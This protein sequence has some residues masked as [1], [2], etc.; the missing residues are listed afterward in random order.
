MI[1]RFLP[2]YRPYK[3][4]AAV[5]LGCA[6]GLGLADLVFPAATAR[7]VDVIV[8]AGDLSGLARFAALLVALYAVRAALE[9]IVGYYGHVLGVNIQHDLRRDIYRH[10]HTMDT[11]FFDNTK[12]G[13]IM[14]R[15]VGDLFDLAEISHHL[16]EDIIMAS[17]RLVGSL[18]VMLAIEWRLAL[19]V[20]AIVPVLVAFSATFREKFR[21]A[22]RRNKE[23]MAAI[24]ERIEES[25]SGVR[26]VRA[27]GNEGFEAERFDEGNATFRKSRIES[28]W[29]IGVFSTGVSF[30]SNLGLV[31]V[32]TAGGFAAFKGAVSL[33]SYVAFALYVSRFFQPIETLV[34][35]M[36]M[37]QEGAA[38]FRRFLEILDTEPTISDAPDA[39]ALA[40]VCG[41]VEFSGV[42]F[43]YG[44]GKERVLER[45][46]LSVAAGETVAIVGP[47]GAGKTTLCS[48]IPRFYDIEEG[49]ITVD[50]LDIRRATIAS[51]R[52][53]V[54]LVQQDVFLF[55]GS[56]REN[57]AYGRLGA[58]DADIEAA[59]RDA[60]A[61][62]FIQG[63]P[64]GFETLVGERGV[65]LSGG[66]KQRIAIARMFLKN[67]PILI[68][69]EATSSLDTMSEQ[70]IRESL[71]RLSAGRTT[72]IIAHRLA[73]IRHAERIL[74][75]T[76]DGIVEQG[77]HDD[78][79]ASGEVYKRLYD[80]QVESLLV[81]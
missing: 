51:L 58:S 48:L 81:S 27:F 42:G 14:S 6:L 1:K 56:V 12:T 74:V 73:T 53:A 5:D 11:R 34:R 78:L 24:N 41:D 52:Q 66:Q 76:E 4:L 29:H 63:L 43:R 39:V 77:R 37:F 59:A 44:E 67:P 17:V 9:F 7:V 69:D 32:L 38:G 60:N 47:S 18:V 64:Q 70:A 50:G 57:I 35:S 79:V 16:P 20:F 31:I 13:Q 72:F 10:L 36:E 30:L 75:L 49:S 68:L 54:G 25:V 61:L 3:G 26:V 22:F 23:T 55:S 62:D 40:S 45:V 80:A 2:Y 8:P 19:V 15:I 21:S 28:V 65:K 33:G 71:E 46:D